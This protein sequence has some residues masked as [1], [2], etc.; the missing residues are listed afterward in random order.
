[1]NEKELIR[2]WNDL[3]NSLIRAQLAPTLFLAVILALGATGHLDKTTP[4]SLRLFAIALVLTS[5]I[6]SALSIMGT[7]RDAQSVIDSLKD[8]KDL[9]M[10]GQKLKASG[11]S[12]FA[13]NIAYVLLPLFN[14]VALGIYLYR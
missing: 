5:G 11:K 12:V 2:I 4:G 7:T 14:F 9:S 8:V 13:A 10:L 1:M 3:R 6:F